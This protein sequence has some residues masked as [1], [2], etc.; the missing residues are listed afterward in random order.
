MET[1]A[2]NSHPI[3]NPT[4]VSVILPTFNRCNYLQEAI[5]SV[6]AQTYPRFELIVIDDGSTDQT[7]ALLE[8]YQ[9]KRLR[10]LNQSN[11]GVS[12]A[13]NQGIRQARGEFI[14]LLDSD[15][16]WRPE[17][18]A[19]QIDFFRTHPHLQICQTEEIWIR[20]GL[21]VNPK[22]RHQKRDGFI[23]EPSLAL[24]LISPSAVMLRAGLM[25]EVGLFDEDLPACEDYDLWLRVTY[26]YPVGLVDKPAVVKRGGHADQLSAGPELDKYRIQALVK[27]L[28]QGVLSPRQETAA[29]A[30]LNQKCRIYASGCRKRGRLAEADH[31]AHLAE[32]WP[33]TQGMI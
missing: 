27:I 6:L 21:R 4:L 5:A 30:M 16:Y 9:D 1:A 19:C 28:G 17:K 12:A 31:Y 14:S 33:A 10:V 13:R 23:F 11:Q 2:A 8:T 3:W 24:C 32:R 15:D 7:T 26:K 18:L 29:K 22:L 20:N 25:E